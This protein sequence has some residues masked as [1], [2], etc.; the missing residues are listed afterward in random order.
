MNNTVK[1]DVLIIGAGPSG[2]ATAIHLADLLK[3]NG[4]EKQI[5]VVDKGQSVGSH[6]L[7][8]A[9]IKPQAFRD[10]LPDVNFDEIPFD[11]KVVSDEMYFLQNEKSSLKVPF[12]PPYMGNSG[13]YCASLGEICRYLA[14]KA[15]EKGVDIYPGFSISDILYDEKGNVSYKCMKKIYDASDNLI[16]MPEGNLAV[17][18][19]LKGYLIAQYNGVLLICKKDEE[20]KIRQFVADVEAMPDGKKFI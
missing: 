15:T 2:L 13:N 19:G 16:V 7:S 5:I 8:G 1:T 9:V 10:L 11:S 20:A 14:A 6:I 17:I 12:H 18:D 3:T 4:I